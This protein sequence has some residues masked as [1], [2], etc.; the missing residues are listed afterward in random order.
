MIIYDFILINI[1]CLLTSLGDVGR[2]LWLD[3]NNNTNNNIYLVKL[4][5]CKE[6]MLTGAL[7]TAPPIKQLGLKYVFCKFHKLFTI[8]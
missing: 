6:K 8:I 5:S 3:V 1:T 4:L 2:G 7:P